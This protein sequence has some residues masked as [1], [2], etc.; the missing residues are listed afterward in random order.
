V[1]GQGHPHPRAYGTFPRVLGTYVR[2]HGVISLE[3]AITRM[4]GLTAWRLGLSDRGLVRPGY[5]ADLVVFDAQ[6]I[7]DQATY[8]SPHAY[9]TGIRWV[10]VNGQ[11]ILRDGERLPALPGRVLLRAGGSRGRHVTPGTE[12]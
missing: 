2:E 11:V 8:D 7:A 3:A 1:L 12:D 4:T 6:R 9:P 5:K 10:L